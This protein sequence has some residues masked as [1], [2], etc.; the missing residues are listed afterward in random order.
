MCEF[1]SN[2]ATTTARIQQDVEP[3]NAAILSRLQRLEDMIM[4]MNSGAP[5]TP[6]S[7]MSRRSEVDGLSAALSPVEESAHLESQALSSI[8][9]KQPSLFP[10]MTFDWVFEALPLETINNMDT[11]AADPPEQQR[12]RRISV[13]TYAD[14][15]TLFDNYARYVCHFHHIIHLPTLRKTLERFYLSLAQKESIDT[16][17][18]ALLICVF[19]TVLCYTRMTGV[20]DIPLQE[21][22]GKDNA[23]LIFFRSTL[24]LLDHSRRVLPGSIEIVQTAIIVVFLDYNLEGFTS[25]ARAIHAQ[26]FLTAKELSMHKLDCAASVRRREVS[27]TLEGLIDTEMKRRIW[28]HL[29]ATD[30]MVSLAGSAQEGTYTA[31][32][33]QMRVRLPRNIDDEVLDRG[34]TSEDPPLTQP[35]AMCYPLHRIRLGEISRSVVD[36]LRFG[37]ADPTE[38]D[39]SQVMLLDKR[40]E[41]F[42]E[43]LPFFFKLDNESIARSQ[44]VLERYPYFAMQRYIIN[45]GV[46]S[47]RCKLH[48]P[49]LVKSNGK[50]QYA[51]SAEICL[52]SAMSVV[53]I[54]KAIRTDSTHYI[55]ERVKL[56]GLL[57][58]MFLATCV[59]VMDLCFN[60][61][62]ANGAGEEDETRRKDVYNAIKML[63]DAK[64]H[65][66]SVQRFLES[67]TEALRKHHIRLLDDRQGV[68]PAVRPDTSTNS[69]SQ[70]I[71]GSTTQPLIG[72]TPVVQNGSQTA[73]LGFDDFWQNQQGYM[74][75]VP[76]WD[77]L[78]GDLDAFIA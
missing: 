18:A 71:N 65:S 70:I 3:T 46:R 16:D 50:A 19:A 9:T 12:R 68:E 21:S 24:D 58:H 5:Q 26:A 37:L 56:Q 11:Y 27:P 17:Q 55:P 40:L 14:A 60:R 4:R 34:S 7:L 2:Q 73:M 20:D 41:H 48:Q 23:F 52:Q 44:Y 39:Y 75:A 10:A 25:R 47:V 78:F 72:S 54:N 1:E 49:F 76:D 61:N 43:D 57:H 22:L 36:A 29:V 8:G 13:P 53:E 77:E 28:W 31:Q 38:H 42:M 51:Q 64:D 30:W 69:W 32:P 74:G 63:E 15:R 45:I 33:Q 35:T 6:D 66:A 59:L 62:V 67:L